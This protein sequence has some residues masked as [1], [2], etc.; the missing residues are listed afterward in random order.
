MFFIL[1]FSQFIFVGACHS[2]PL[3]IDPSLRAA[4][5]YFPSPSVLRCLNHS[6]IPKEFHKAIISRLAKIPGS[7]DFKQNATL[8][9]KVG[10]TKKF[11]FRGNI[12][13]GN[14]IVPVKIDPNVVFGLN[15]K[16]GKMPGFFGLE[17]IL[18]LQRKIHIKDNFNGQSIDY[19]I[20][21]RNTKGMIGNSNYTLDLFG[22]DK[23]VAGE[24]RY[25]LSGQGKI[26]KH[27]ITV[28]ARDVEKDTY[29]IQE[30]Y[31]PIK[32][33]TSVRVYD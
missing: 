14:E 5:L 2:K 31:G 28:R 13:R 19:E 10:P 33:I 4:A 22:Q 29:E 15:K 32:V 8:G 11:I 7:P 30:Q 17:D 26:G 27:V 9:V 18:G 25:F 3:Q 12:I 6:N 20:F 23:N 21:L 1:L 24:T 16:G